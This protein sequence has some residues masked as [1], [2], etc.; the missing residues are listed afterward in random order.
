MPDTPSK[1]IITRPPVGD[2]ALT[3]YHI[4]RVR[5]PLFE[6]DLGQGVYH[7]NYFHLLELGREDF[8]R[9]IGF[10]YKEFMNR[11]LH[12]AVVEAA[13]SYRKP[14]RYDEMIEIHTAVPWTRTRSVGFFQVIFREG[15][16]GTKQLC[17]RADLSMVCIRFSGRPAL[18]PDEFV[19]IIERL[20]DLGIEQL[21]PQ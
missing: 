7:G 15:K 17:T 13:V 5:V 20:R 9:T 21:K 18:L 12:L 11:Q 1:K 6:I 14:L 10:P 2:G 16:D 8:L 4:T 3:S 19:E